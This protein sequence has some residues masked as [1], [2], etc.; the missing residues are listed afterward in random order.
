[1]KNLAQKYQNEKIP[2]HWIVNSNIRTFE[3]LFYHLQV[4]THFYF[5]FM[6]AINKFLTKVNCK[7]L[8][9]AD[10][11]GGVGWASALMAKDERIKKVYLVEPSVNRVK[12][13]KYIC[14]HLNI[15]EKKFEF[16]DGDFQNFNL[17]EKVDFFLMNASF[18]HCLDINLDSLFENIKR[19]LKNTDN[20]YKL[21]IS[22]EHYVNWPFLLMRIR[23]LL[24]NILK[25]KKTYY[26][27]FNLRH[28]DPNDHEC[29]RSLS[30]LKNI[31]KKYGYCADFNNFKIDLCN[32][33]S[34]FKFLIAYKY[35]YAILRKKSGSI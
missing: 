6:H 34:I 21:L 27:L 2:S 4:K 20:E 32:D 8:V 3:R 17:P 5:G 9:V 1:M 13:F 19:F 24:I 18:H 31:F 30:E 23:L 33:K 11:G 26:S 25:N 16:I 28:Y 15:P 14:Y 10:V 29:W 22:N 12:S 7:N 35:Y